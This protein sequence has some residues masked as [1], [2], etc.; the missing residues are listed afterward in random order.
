MNEAHHPR[1]VV[2]GVQAVSVKTAHTPPKIKLSTAGRMGNKAGAPL[3]KSN[4]FDERKSNLAT[5]VSVRAVNAPIP[6]TA[7]RPGTPSVSQ[8]LN[9]SG[10]AAKPVVSQARA[11]PI[12]GRNAQATPPMQSAVSSLKLGRT[13]AARVEQN[14]CAT[15]GKSLQVSDFS[16]SRA[17]CS[18]CVKR[19]SPPANLRPILIFTG[20]TTAVLL[21][22]GIF[23][24]SQALL[25]GLFSGIIAAIAGAAGHSLRRTTRLAAGAGGLLVIA[26]TSYGLIAVGQSN[27]NKAARAEYIGQAEEI[28]RLLS[29]NCFLEAELRID[30][31]GQQA[32]KLGAGDNREIVTSAVAELRALTRGWIEQHYG[33]L[34]SV[35][36]K[37]LL[38]LV[39]GLG[40]LTPGTQVPRVRALAVSRTDV[41]V[42]I[43]TDTQKPAWKRAT[44]DPQTSS[45]TIN[46]DP[47]EA[48]ADRVLLLIEKNFSAAENVDVK[49]TSA[50]EGEQELMRRTLSHQ[51]LAELKQKLSHPRARPI[52]ATDPGG[53]PRVLR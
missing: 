8:Y 31:I 40:S 1:K 13:G 6:K 4:S 12:P 53:P 29:Q 45:I 39:R 10:K 21:V 14:R 19:K 46:D 52:L 7:L 5:P 36:E 24:P 49:L 27:K 47:L 22:I 15:C 25:V 18:A 26:L 48:E 17:H 44:D 35:E 42:T 34:S 30:A 28:K 9:P 2:S 41:A 32:I 16:P 23:L 50:K 37:L 38:D 20:V 3:D 11:H 51:E 33:K 43:A